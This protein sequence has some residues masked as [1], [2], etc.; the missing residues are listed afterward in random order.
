MAWH[1]GLITLDRRKVVVFMNNAT[2]YPVAIY[3]PK[4]RDYRCMKHLIRE[5]IVAALRMEG[6]SEPVIAR[7]M[8]DAGE[9][10]FSAAQ[11]DRLLEWLNHAV[12]N[13]SWL[14]RYLDGDHVI[15]RYVSLPAARVVQ[16]M[17]DGKE[18]YPINQLLRH[19]GDL[20]SDTVDGIRQPVIDTKGYL[21]EIQLELKGFEVWRRVVVPSAFSF[22]HLHNVIQIVFDWHNAHLHMFKAPKKDLVPQR[23]IFMEEEPDI[24]VWAQSLGV[25]V[26]QE[27]LTPLEDVLPWHDH[28]VYQYDFGD[29]WTHRI[30]IEKT[31]RLNTFAAIY[32]DGK[33]ERPPEDVGGASGY[34]SFM[35]AMAD[36]R[37]PQ[38]KAMKAWAHGRLA[39]RLSPEEINDRLL[40]DALDIVVYSAD[41]I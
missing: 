36:Q 26:L 4:P 30:S 17:P 16:P 5:A 15:Q 35:R 9:I 1:A 24:L 25:Q 12:L 23:L 11:D 32:V 37:H 18:D 21:L 41:W 3:R 8:A 27:R 38:H 39:R 22:Q 28:V 6:I 29:N 2:R 7:Y 13:V 34:T 19:L 20:Y 31:V 40:H 33:G 10:K 14:K